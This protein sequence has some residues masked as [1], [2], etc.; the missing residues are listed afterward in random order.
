M[1]KGS[2]RSQHIEA[3]AVDIR[4]RDVSLIELARYCYSN[5]DYDQL[6][7]EFYD[8]LDPNKGWVHISREVVDNRGQ[9]LIY[10]GKRYSDGRKGG[11]L[12]R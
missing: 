3:L 10:D 12:R 5:I 6:I 1:I 11:I 4:M 2:Q 7:L 8:A 9:F